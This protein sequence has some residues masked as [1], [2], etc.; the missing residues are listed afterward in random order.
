[1]ICDDAFVTFSYFM[2]IDI[3]SNAICLYRLIWLVTIL[4]KI[5]IYQS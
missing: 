4:R 1:M 5:L 3:N 2:L